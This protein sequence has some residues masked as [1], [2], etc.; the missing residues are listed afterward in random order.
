[1]YEEPD[2]DRSVKVFTAGGLMW[3][4]L[5]FVY[6]WP[7]ASEALGLSLAP[8]SGHLFWSAQCTIA[9]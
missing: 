5:N 2:I 6:I 4:S 1:M 8:P 9:F 3:I 7:F